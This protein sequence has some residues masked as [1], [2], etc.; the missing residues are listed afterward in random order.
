MGGI[1][2]LKVCVYA[3]CKNESQFADRF[4][5]SMSEADYVCVLDTGSSDDTVKKLRARG[6]IVGE[7]VV[8]PWRFDTARNESLGLIPADA[9]I[10]CAIDLDEQFHPGWRAALER[11]WQPDTTRARYRYTWSF[12]PD[13]SEGMVFWAD[14]IHKNGCYRW[15]SPVHETLAYTGEGAE[16]F[17]DAAGVQ[18]DHHPDETKSRGQYLP[19]LELAIREDPQND[20]N[21]HYLGREYMFR[22]EWQKAIETLARHLTLPSA[23]WADERCASMRYIARCLRALEQDDSAERWLH[24]AV[25]EAPHLRE[26][27]M[28]YAQLLYTQERWYG[29]VDVLRAA[30]AITERPRTYICEADAW[31]S[32]PYDLL[33]LAYAHLGDAEN[34]ADACRKAVERSPQEERL[35]KN[36]ALFEQMRER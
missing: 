35:R 13:G 23:V 27:Y 3:I 8:S 6:A 10:C 5:D 11:A 1:F 24:R 19:L 33:S 14:K 2:A 32:L 17:V 4:M 31:G 29:L 18:L 12:R 7:T 26:P 34:A 21:C 25:A 22:G 28:D 30:L 36:L 15:A 20:R 9:D 16:R